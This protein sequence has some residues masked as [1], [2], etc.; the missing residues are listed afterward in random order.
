MTALPL[1]LATGNA[2]LAYNF[3]FLGAFVLSGFSAYLLAYDLVRNRAGAILAG[4]AFAF[5]AY[6]FNHLS[7]INLVTL[8][9]M[10]LVLFALRRS[11][12]QD[13]RVFPVLFAVTLVL[14]ALSSWYAALMTL[15][16]VAVYLVYFFVFQR[17]QINRRRI[18][19]FALWLGIALVPIALVAW[20]Y[21]QVSRE[22]Q[23]VRGLEEAE[24]FSARPLSFLSVAPFNWLYGQVLPV[25]VGEALFPGLVILVCAVL[26]LRKRF[27]FPDR[28]FL[29]WRNN[30]IRPHCVRPVFQ[31]GPGIELP[32][33]LYRLLYEFVPG[34]QGTR[35]LHVFLSSA[36][37]ESCCSRRTGLARSHKNCPC[38]YGGW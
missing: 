2:V 6:K 31:V 23:F 15:L 24:R 21:F 32:S 5:W 13:R 22:L 18:L 9:W 3:V 33:P 20:P 37:W 28:A 12:M 7:H 29:D 1:W 30:F 8:Q 38:R 16:V 10:P 27:A 11:L 26:G 36:C 25:A 4:A 14:Q 35:H 19:Q 34:F 17:A